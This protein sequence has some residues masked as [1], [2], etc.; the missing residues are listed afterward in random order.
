[1]SDAYQEMID[2]YHDMLKAEGMNFT[3]PPAPRRGGPKVGDRVSAMPD[4]YSLDAGV[5]VESAWRQR[6]MQCPA[7]HPAIKGDSD[8][9]GWHW[10][11]YVTVRFRGGKTRVGWWHSDW[12]YKD[13]KTGVDLA[14]SFEPYWE[15]IE[16]EI[17]ADTPVRNEDRALPLDR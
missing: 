13:S 1:M 5:V 15:Q 4:G 7:D 12:A 11:W 17:K 14:K 2:K 3:P 9:P 10:G 16:A 6:D 8:H